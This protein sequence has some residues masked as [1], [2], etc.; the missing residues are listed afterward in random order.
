[1][2][3]VSELK[4]LVNSQCTFCSCC[5]MPQWD[6]KH[7]FCACFSRFFLSLFRARDIGG[8]WKFFSMPNESHTN[9][10]PR[11]NSLWILIPNFVFFIVSL[12]RNCG[13][14]EFVCYKAR[15]TDTM[16]WFIKDFLFVLS[17]KIKVFLEEF[18]KTSSNETIADDK[19]ENY[20]GRRRRELFLCPPAN[21]IST[22]SDRIAPTRIV[23]A[24][25]YLGS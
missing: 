15:P 1:M 19:V 25:C 17:T 10:H 13:L 24:V 20:Y 14:L 16:T 12:V 11:I 5:W 9:V 22:H 8:N 21:F 23:W 2:E 3:I 18:L 4:N 7:V 6:S